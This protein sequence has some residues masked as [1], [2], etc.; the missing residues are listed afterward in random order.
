MILHVHRIF[1]EITTFPNSSVWEE[2]ETRKEKA[3][4]SGAPAQAEKEA[5]CRHTP[6]K[7]AECPDHSSKE[8]AEC[9][10]SLEE[11][12]LGRERAAPGEGVRLPCASPPYIGV[13]GAGFLP[14]K[15]RGTK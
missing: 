1:F 5:E 10:D 7:G 8:E 11:E 2:S 9:P 6:E 4:C 12:V 14:S 13:E 3:G 15:C